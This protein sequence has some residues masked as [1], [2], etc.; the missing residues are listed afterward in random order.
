MRL[1]DTKKMSSSDGFIIGVTEKLAFSKFPPTLFHEMPP[2][3]RRRDMASSAGAI[4]QVSNMHTVTRLWRGRAGSLSL[5]RG[6]SVSK[7]QTCATSSAASRSARGPL[8]PPN[9]HQRPRS[10]KAK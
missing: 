6:K 4:S 10:P 2:V 8:S 9:L 1:T 5:Q 7:V 3:S